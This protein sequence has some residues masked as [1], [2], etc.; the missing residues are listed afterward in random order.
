MVFTQY[1]ASKNVVQK[2]AALTLKMMQWQSRASSSRQLV[3][4]RGQT[5]TFLQPPHPQ[6]A[7]VK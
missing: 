6:S 5:S 2:F 4:D 3:N 1:F 7:D